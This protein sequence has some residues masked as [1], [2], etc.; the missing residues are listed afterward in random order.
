[1]KYIIYGTGIFSEVLLDEITMD[2]GEVLAFTLD[3]DLIETETHLNRPLIPFSKVE[4][5]YSPSEIDLLIGIT[6]QNKNE[7]RR[8]YYQKGIE[9]GYP[10]NG[11][12]SKNSNLSENISIG[13]NNIVLSGNLIQT[14]VQIGENNILW[15]TNHIG[16][17]SK[18]S[19]NCFISSHVII[20][21][22]CEVGEN[23]FFGVNSTVID[24]IIIGDYSL[25]GAG[26]VVKENTEENEVVK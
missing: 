16:H 3:D 25:I 12:I 8:E 14:D 10:M 23:V 22:N 7:T 26:A 1:M 5:T 18:I 17:H 2:N 19:N 4:D 6:Y 13:L 21:G 20:S 15:N 24:N 11:F 9:K